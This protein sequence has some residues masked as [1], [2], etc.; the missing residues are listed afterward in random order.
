MRWDTVPITVND[1][2]STDTLPM[3]SN[4]SIST[5]TIAHTFDPP[6]YYVID[7][8]TVGVILSVAQLQKIDSDLEMLKL[9][10]QLDNQVQ[11]VDDFYISVINDQNEKIS[12]LETTLNNV[13]DQTEGQEEL[14]ENLKRQVRMKTDQ[15]ELSEEQYQ[16]DLI[17]IEGLKKDLRKQKVKTWAGSAGAGALGI[18]GIILTIFLLK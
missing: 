6:E 16:N 8:D 1:S 17:I 4:D 18:G 5:D 9:F 7:G 2:I 15:Y 14:I 10:K 12:I 13:K 3:V 11:G